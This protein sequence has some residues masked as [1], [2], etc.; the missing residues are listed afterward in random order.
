MNEKWRSGLGAIFWNNCTG[1]RKEDG[2]W[3]YTVGQYAIS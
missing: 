2:S 3:T 1:Q